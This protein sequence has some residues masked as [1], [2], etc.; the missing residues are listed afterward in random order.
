[1][2]ANCVCIFGLA[3]QLVATF[4]GMLCPLHCGVCLIRLI[5]YLA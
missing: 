2:K 1:M 5:R 3:I 4:W